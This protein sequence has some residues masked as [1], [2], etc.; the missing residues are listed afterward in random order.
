MRAL[1]ASVFALAA[2]DASAGAALAQDVLDPEATVAV[3]HHMQEHHGGGRIS[4]VEGERFEYQS[5]EGDPVFLW[6]AQ[7]FFGGDLNKLWVK[8]EGEYDFAA[9]E[10][11]EA[12]VQALFSRAIGSFWDIQAGVRRDFAPFEDRTYG[13][14]GV[15]GLAPYLFEIDAAFFVSGHGDVTARIETEYEFLLTQRLVLQPRAELNFAMQDVP[16]LETGSGLSTA[17]AGLRLR[18]EIRR[19]FAPYV[20][21][22]WERS[23]GDTADFARAAGE[24]LSKISLVAGLRFWF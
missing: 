11:E 12:E 15:Q 5:N 10:F 21:V 20:G 1:P 24:D 17:E 2:L 16:E 4:Y 13:V 18:Y 23:V 8:T 3:R 14:V 22:S 9:D 7:G 6:D 19:E